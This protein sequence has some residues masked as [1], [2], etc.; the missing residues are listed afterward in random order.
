MKNRL[1]KRE[2]D[3]IQLLD[4]SS[5]SYDG[6]TLVWV[7]KAADITGMKPSAVS[8]ALKQLVSKKLVKVVSFQEVT[9]ESTVIP[10]ASKGQKAVIQ[11]VKN[12]GTSR[13]AYVNVE[14]GLPSEVKII[15][16]EATTEIANHKSILEAL[17]RLRKVNFVVEN[18]LEY[19]PS[20]RIDGVSRPKSNYY[21]LTSKKLSKDAK[22]IVGQAIPLKYLI[23]ESNL[24]NHVV[25]RVLHDLM[26]A[27]H[28]RL[29]YASQNSEAKKDLQRIIGVV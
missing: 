14:S 26:L 15:V 29:V 16:N 4:S 3:L 27:G 19:Q 12:K 1:G 2:Y 7:S 28:V 22:S 10:K 5:D 13:K 23:A 21:K 11:N 6:N 25:K 17:T 8:R 24:P 18:V 20:I 9:V